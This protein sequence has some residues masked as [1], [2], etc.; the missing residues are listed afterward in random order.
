MNKLQKTH[1]IID[2][3][4]EL[5]KSKFNSSDFVSLNKE[6]QLTL[7]EIVEEIKGDPTKEITIDDKN[8]FFDLISKIESLE[9]KILPKAYLMDSFSK[10]IK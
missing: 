7:D 9:A 2:K 1:S 4:D 6:F 10:S 5:N 8:N 3:L